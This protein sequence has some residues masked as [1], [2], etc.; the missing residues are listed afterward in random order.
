LLALGDHISFRFAFYAWFV[1]NLARYIPGNIWQV[2][3]MMVLVERQGVSKMNAL[4]SQA[5]YAV[6]ALSVAALFG[7]TLL[8]FAREYLLFA[9]LLFAGL[10]IFF[11]LPP[12]F[13]LMLHITARATQ[14]IRKKTIVEPGKLPRTSFTRGLLP[15]LCS[16]A[17][18]TINGCAFYLFVR[19]LADISPTQL[20]SFIA[21]NAAA[22]FIGYVSFIT[23]SGLGFREGALAFMLASFL[24]PPFSAVPVAVAL[25]FLTRIWST[26][27]EMLGV[28]IALWGAPRKLHPLPFAPKDRGE[29]SPLPQ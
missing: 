17:M 14:L 21:M 5:V 4:L 20:P 6:V 19:S 18:W 10:I 7:L 27:G 23:P 2:A 28:G 11:A 25:S 8:P 15:P 9:A 13:R 24:P 22:Y 29:V 1:S 16:S 12:V 3:A 26:V